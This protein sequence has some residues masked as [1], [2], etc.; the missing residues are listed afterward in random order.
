[1]TD[2]GEYLEKFPYTARLGL[3][4]AAFPFLYYSQPA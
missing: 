3:K 1:M 4:P 2:P